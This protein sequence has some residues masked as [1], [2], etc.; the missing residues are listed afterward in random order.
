M[1]KLEVGILGATG[2][3]GQR[4]ASLLEHHPWFEVK[5]LGASEKS[6]GKKYAEACSWR[7]RERMPPGLRE[8][9]VEECKPGKIFRNWF[10]P[11]SIRKSPARWS[12]SSPAPA[13]P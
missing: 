3:V 12:A 6:T 11:R 7:L 4:F 2:M 5:W 1:K 9:V 10:F 13:T 8:L